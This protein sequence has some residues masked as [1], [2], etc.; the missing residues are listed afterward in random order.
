MTAGTVKPL[1]SVRGLSVGTGPFVAV[2][3]VSFD[4]QPGEML[5][6]VGESGSGKTATGRAILGLLPPGLK[7]LAGSITIDGEDLTTVTPARLRE[8]RGGSIGMVFQ[9]PMVS[10]NPALSIG[11]QLGEALA[12]HSPM[13]PEEQHAACLA[14][15]RRIQIPDPEGCLRAYP[16]EF[17]GG[18]RQRIML[19]AVMLP[20]PKLL[21]ADEPT[22]ALDNLVQA[23]IL[24]LMVE[25]AKDRGTAVLLVTHNL[26]LV[27]RYADRALVMQRG[28]VVEEGRA[29]ELLRNPRHPYTRDLVAAMPR[30]TPRPRRVAAAEP[31][32]EVRGF[33]VDYPGSRGLFR[34]GAAKRAV[35]GVDLTIA[36][37]ETVA[38]VGGSGCGKTTLGRAMLR[39]IT[40]SGGQLLFRGRDV[41]TVRGAALKDFRLACQIVFQDPYSSLDPRMRVGEIVAEPLRHETGLDAAAKAARVVETFDAV[42]LP[43]M[44]DRFPHQLSGGQRQRV[45]I[46]R[47]IVRRPA[48]VV[49]DE[50]VSALDMT[51][52]KQILEL[53]RRLQEERGFACLFISHDLGAVAEVADRVVVMQAGRIVEQGSRDEVFD[54]PRH[55]YTR[56]LLDATP[57]IEAEV[58]MAEVAVV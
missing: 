2:N 4:I 22:T 40:A 29:G 35:D 57:R 5:A 53:I 10:L 24:N 58:A 36:L 37:G 46:A 14:M 11:A 23:E 12:L 25:L 21:I 17:S 27:S 42:G 18:M 38:L 8:L 7:R 47:A 33:T 56:A 20:A 1:L 9:E 16:H 49:A 19:A 15:L 39:L 52:Q 55:P 13:S 31:L 44:A 43:G 3:D 28:K 41:S 6:L 50:P 26:G 51:V 32:L 48:L 54:H 34:R 45:A 30:R